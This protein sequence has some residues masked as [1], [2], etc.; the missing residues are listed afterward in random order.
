MLLGLTQEQ[1]DA[2]CDAFINSVNITEHCRQTMIAL[3]A[4]RDQV[5]YGTQVGSTAPQAPV[6]PVVGTTTYTDGIVKQ[7]FD[8]R[9]QIILNKNYT[10]AIGEDLG[11]VGAADPGKSEDDVFP[12]LKS[13]TASPGF[14]VQIKGSMQ[15]MDAMRIEYA[16]AGG[17][18]AT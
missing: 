7:F 1:I 12:T 9:D 5:L 18:F 4:W 14:T 10:E 15:G 16:P 13:V 17:D 11:I 6:F 3:T 2:I 8:L